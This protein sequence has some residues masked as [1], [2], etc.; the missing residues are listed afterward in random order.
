MAEADL[1]KQVLTVLWG[2]SRDDRALTLERQDGYTL[3][4]GVRLDR[5]VK[6]LDRAADLF[7]G[8]ESQ[9]ANAVLLFLVKTAAKSFEFQVGTSRK[10]LIP[11]ATVARLAP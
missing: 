8:A 7:A 5:A 4:R 11:S 10:V 1:R 3:A 2:K 9:R 6:K